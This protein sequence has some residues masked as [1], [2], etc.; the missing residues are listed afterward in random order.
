MKYFP[1]YENVDKNRFVNLYLEGFERYCRQLAD[2]YGCL[3]NQG[4]ALLD[5]DADVNKDSA[6]IDDLFIIPSFGTSATSA[7]NFTAEQQIL[8]AKDNVSVAKML[9]AKP[10]QFILGDPGIGKSTFLHWLAISLAH[11]R[12][13]YVQQAIGPLLPILLRVRD[14]RAY[15]TE[16]YDPNGFLVNLKSYLGSLGELLDLNLLTRAMV[17]GQV[18]L[19]VDGLDEIG[20]QEMLNLGQTLAM[21]FTQYPSCRC[22]MTARVVG[23]EASMLWP[24]AKNKKEVM[25]LES[26]EQNEAGGLELELEA[27]ALGLISDKQT[28]SSILSRKAEASQLHDFGLYY[29][30]PLNNEQR[31]QFSQKWCKIYIKNS[32]L[33][34]RFVEEL[35]VAF[36]DNGSLNNLS[37]TPVLLNM[38]CF[39]QQ[40]R[41]R[42]PNGRAELYQKII[43]T[44]LVS[45]DRARGIENNFID[46]EEFDYTDIRNWLAKLAY[47]MQLGKIDELLKSQGNCIQIEDLLF[48]PTGLRNTSLTE[49]ELIIFF[50]K[51]L[52]EIYED[53]NKCEN[54]TKELIDYIKRRTGFLIDR[55]QDAEQGHETIFAFSH[56]SFQ[57]YFAAH[58]ISQ[59]WSQLSFSNKLVDSLTLSCNSQSWFECWQLVF[60][61]FSQNG[62]NR[63]QHT[64]FIDKLFGSIEELEKK[65]PSILI[66]ILSKEDYAINLLSKIVINPAVKLLPNYRQSRLADLWLY[67]LRINSINGSSSIYTLWPELCRGYNK[68][69]SLSRKALASAFK[70]Y[71]RSEGFCLDLSGVKSTDFRPIKLW[72]NLKELNLEHS[73]IDNLN[74]LKDFNDLEVLSLSNTRVTDLKLLSKFTKLEVL[75][76]SGTAVTDFSPL[77]DL[78]N[79]T[80]LFMGWTKLSDISFLTNLRKL[81]HISIQYTD[82]SSLT[83]FS[84]L[85]LLNSM[86]VAGTNVS[87]LTPIVNLVG[88]ERLDVSFTNVSSLEPLVNLHQ[89]YSLRLSHTH[90]FDLS[91]LSKLFRVE[92]L[93]IANTDVTDLEPLSKIKRMKN[94]NI[95]KTKILDLAPLSKLNQ[96]TILGISG[97]Q[98]SDLA[99]LTELPKLRSVVAR[100]CEKL[101]MINEDCKFRVLL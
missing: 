59:Q 55:G 84:G 26:L 24:V 23:F 53:S 68:E 2:Y 31:L 63:H 89:L 10:R 91:P 32:D 25:T 28:S 30:Q 73:Y 29:I 90:V 14:F 48:E 97:T 71:G 50:T 80:H 58:F 6:F 88:L 1:E 77:A 52:R 18:L 82:V 22:I 62:N 86:D 38:I 54:I 99:P 75:S 87:D 44:Y 3:N 56:L 13:N 94:L 67:N 85:K 61:D 36:N 98:V 64:L 78:S 69:D 9:A 79:I 20:K 76:L 70:N 83:S 72:P 92:E 60:E 93:S 74:P 16:P 43:E 12:S 27:E 45:M 7:E 4:L 46:S 11:H 57:E 35:Q 21:L 39:I 37:R 17:N 8:Q 101:N 19:L 95:S 49:N 5:D 34:E 42:L 66:N 15:L 100:G 41:G 96:L 51:E 47:V 81:K 33:H 40:R 65:M